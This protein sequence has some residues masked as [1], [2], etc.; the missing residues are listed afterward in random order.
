MPSSH[1]HRLDLPAERLLDRNARS[2]GDAADFLAHHAS[3]LVRIALLFCVLVLA[4]CG[5]NTTRSSNYRAWRNKKTWTLC[6]I[7]PGRSVSSPSRPWPCRRKRWRRWSLWKNWAGSS[8]SAVRLTW[9]GHT[10][11]TS[12]SS[13]A[14]S[15]STRLASP[16]GSCR[17]A[18]PKTPAMPAR[19]CASP[20]SAWALAGGQKALGYVGHPCCR[21]TNRTKAYVLAN[22]I[23]GRGRLNVPARGR[24]SGR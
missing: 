19:A 10:S 15:A 4:G 13:S 3:F 23:A 22:V 17:R 24:R 11:P 9:L 7:S 12:T 14:R 8:R 1:E 18:G 6:T 20:P 16:P 2:H 21:A 5:T